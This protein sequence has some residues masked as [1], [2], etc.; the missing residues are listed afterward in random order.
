MNIPVSG[1]WDTHTQSALQRYLN[2]R[3][4]AG[5]TIDGEAGYL[6]ICALQEFL[7]KVVK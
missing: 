6:T 2:M 1:K 4:D 3:N 7:N 5:L